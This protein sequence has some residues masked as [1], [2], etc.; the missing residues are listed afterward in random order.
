MPGARVNPAMARRFAQARGRRAKTDMLDAAM[1]SELGAMFRPAPDDPPCPARETLT[2]LAKRRDQ[3]VA[4]RQAEKVRLKDAVEPGLRRCHEDMIA[5]FD[6]R[7]AELE[8]Q[9]QSL[10]AGVEAMAQD[11]RLLRTAPGVG[12]VAAATCLS[13]LPELGRLGPKKIAALAGL[14]PFNH[15]SGRKRG[16]RVIAG[17]RRRVRQALYMAALGAIRSCKRYRRFY[18]AVAK[19][20]GAKKVAIIAV[21]RKLLTHLNAMIRDRK[22]WA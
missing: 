22:E 6:G 4:M 9:I 5:M 16:K 13:L 14:A 3:I 17:G 10:I 11:A 7:I 12:P 21:A 2:W 1:L 15:D 18:D 19:R 20:A 8:K